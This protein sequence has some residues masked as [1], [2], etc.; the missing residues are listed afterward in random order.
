P[1]PI[2]ETVDQKLTVLDAIFELISPLKEGLLAKEKAVEASKTLGLRSSNEDILEAYKSYL[3][4][5]KQQFRPAKKASRSNSEQEAAQSENRIRLKALRDEA[6]ARNSESN[7]EAAPQELSRPE[8]LLLETVLT[9]PECVQNEQIVEI[10]DLI[11]HS[12]VKEL[13]QWL[14]R[15]YLEIDESDYEHILQRKLSEN[16]SRAVNDVVASALFQHN[17]LKLESKVVEKTLKDCAL[18]LKVE[19]LKKQ[20]RA[21]A[22]EQKASATEAESVEY[23]NKILEVEKELRDLKY[24]S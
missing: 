2:P 23:L 3:K 14:K 24:N 4:T 13:I 22:N 17:K 11:D 5:Q 1:H 16:Y 21:L 20:K 10:L 12:E 8:K 15:I 9:H 6:P 19:K 18:K 7:N